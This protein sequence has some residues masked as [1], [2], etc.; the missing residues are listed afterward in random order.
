MLLK[1]GL[2]GTGRMG[3]QIR[4]VIADS[5]SCELVSVWSQSGEGDESHLLSRNLH[6]VVDRADVVVDFT[7]PAAT[8][9]VVRAAVSKNKP[10]LC[11]VSGLNTAQREELARAAEHIPLLYDRNMSIGVAVLS[12]MLRIASRS[13]LADFRCE[14]SETH[15]VRKIDAPS[16]TALALGEI[17]AEGRGQPFADVMRIGNDDSNAPNRPDTINMLSIREGD[18]PGEHTVTFASDSETLTLTHSVTN[19]RVFA[20]GAVLAA[21]WLAKQPAGQYRMADVLS[22]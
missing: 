17:I 5:T 12:E 8:S 18:V 14:I 4:K 2:L 20:T 15:H 9:A 10:L 13:A 3:S 7:L 11:G 22:E 6:S 1:I 16:G 21:C 19:R